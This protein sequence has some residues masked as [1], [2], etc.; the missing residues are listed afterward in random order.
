MSIYM[1]CS[2]WQSANKFTDYSRQSK[3]VM[4]SLNQQTLINGYKIE[5]AVRCL[6]QRVKLWIHYASYKFNN[7]H[8]SDK[9]AAL[10]ADQAAVINN[11]WVNRTVRS[12][13]FQRLHFRV[14]WRREHF[15]ISGLCTNNRL[16]EL[17][18]N[19][20]LHF[21]QPCVDAVVSTFQQIYF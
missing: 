14:R 10:N 6:Q 21:L 13:I 11:D 20:R 1:Q 12:D 3:I 5:A 7:L 16:I 17:A 2:L 15:Y 4:I 9:Q 19:I 18:W 8:I